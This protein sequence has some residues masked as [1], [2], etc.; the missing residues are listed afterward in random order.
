MTE[1]DITNR[2]VLTRQRRLLNLR[3]RIA[4]LEEESLE[5]EES[6]GFQADGPNEV[7]VSKKRK[8]EFF[9]KTLEELLSGPI[10]SYISIQGS[11]PTTT[12]RISANSSQNLTTLNV[13]QLLPLR[14]ILSDHRVCTGTNE[15]NSKILP[16]KQTLEPRFLWEI[17]LTHWMIL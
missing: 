11:L 5:L 16:R 4:Q 8:Q 6:A 9:T 15:I 10:D 3:T 7:H 14:L 1:T 12:T 13:C 2:L 17:R